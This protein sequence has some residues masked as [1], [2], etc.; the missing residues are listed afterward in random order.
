MENSTMRRLCW[1][2]VVVHVERTNGAADRHR[3]WMSWSVGGQRD[4]LPVH[5]N[6][7]HAI[8][9]VQAVDYS[10]HTVVF[11]LLFLVDNSSVVH[12]C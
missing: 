9:S 7:N 3:C 5:C 8:M 4:F 11:V 12:S 10:H 2:A 6:G 1:V